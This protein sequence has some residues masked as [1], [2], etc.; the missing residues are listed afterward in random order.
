MSATNRGAERNERD[1]YPTPSSAIEPIL[2][3][4]NFTNIKSFL[5]P[6][7][8][9]GDIYDLV[10]VEEKLYAELSEGIDYFKNDFISNGGGFRSYNYKPTF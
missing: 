3:E 4:I 2:K 9:K 5:E 6:C 7:R 1:F 8:G 10:N